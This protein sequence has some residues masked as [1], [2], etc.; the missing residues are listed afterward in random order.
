VLLVVSTAATVVG[1]VSPASAAATSTTADF[2]TDGRPVSHVGHS[3]RAGTDWA[4]ERA[5]ADAV[6]SDG[7]TYW[8]GQTLYADAFDADSTVD[9]RRGTPTD[10]SGLAGLAFADGD[11]E[12]ALPTDSR[13]AGKHYLTDGQGRTVTFRLV[14]QALS[15]SFDDRTAS[16]RGPDARATLSIRTG[17]GTSPLYLTMIAAGRAVD[18]TAFRS[19]VGEGRTA[20]VDDDGNDEA[21]RLSVNASDSLTL[22]FSNRSAGTYSLVATVPDTT[23]RATANISVGS[24]GPGTADFATNVVTGIGGVVAIPATFTV[25]PRVCE[26]DDAP[27][28]ESYNDNVEQVPS[29]VRGVVTDGRIHA[30]VDGDT[31]RDYTAVTGPDRRLS[32]LRPGQ[33][34]DSTVAVENDCET[35]TTVV[36]ASDPADGFVSEYDAGDTTVRGVGIANVVA[37]EAVELGVR[38]GRTLGLL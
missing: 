20:D 12:V 37:V 17:R 28:V 19:I 4:V 31:Q 14:R 30:V 11:G 33:P 35:L 38:I 5:D 3:D 16:N 25:A 21:I 27:L 32:E 9:P 7:G 1:P 6:T 2:G 10:D 22:D 18:G 36:D 8:V 23:A 29:F 26:R 34:S 24:S 15:V 13:T